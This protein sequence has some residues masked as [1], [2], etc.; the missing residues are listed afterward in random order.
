VAPGH[1]LVLGNTGVRRASAAPDG[2]PSFMTSKTPEEL[3]K[4]IERES[5]ENPPADGHDRTA[6][7]LEVERPLRSIFLRNLK[8][9][10]KPE[11]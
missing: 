6:E 1:R 2:Y 9:V 3:K 10:S 8:K 5:W 7:G 4:Q 11:D